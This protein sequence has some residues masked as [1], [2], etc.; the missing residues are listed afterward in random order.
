MYQPYYIVEGIR[1]SK[2]HKDYETYKHEDK[3][4]EGFAQHI[5]S[6]KQI[7]EAYEEY[8]NNY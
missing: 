8:K 3:M 1:I 4:R 6:T 2:N 5:S 7:Q